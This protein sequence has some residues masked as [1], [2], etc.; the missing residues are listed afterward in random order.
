[1]RTLKWDPWSEP[2]VETTVGVAWI[3]LP[4]LLP[5][6]FAKKDIFLI[7][8]AVGKSLVVDM[9]TRNHTRPNYASAKIE[10]DLVA[11]LQHK[12]KI[13]EEVDVTGKIKSK[14]I[15]VQYEQKE[16]IDKVKEDA[17]E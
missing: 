5:N 13:N 3:S 7:A 9:A 4:D 11:K 6:I 12:I 2:D 8:S 16:E 15:H 17:K 14:W 10:V 1:M